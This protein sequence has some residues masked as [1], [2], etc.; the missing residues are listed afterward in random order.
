M[1]ESAA[2]TSVM[3]TPSVEWVFNHPT[4]SVARR[5]RRTAVVAA[6]QR[7]SASAEPGANVIRSTAIG[8]CDRSARARS[9]TS[10]S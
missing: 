1:L 6:I 9:L 4:T 3:I 10:T 7:S 2:L 5:A 8:R